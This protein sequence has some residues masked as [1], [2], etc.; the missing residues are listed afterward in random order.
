MFS[1]H[2]HMRGGRVFIAK[3]GGVP[4]FNGELASAI[5]ERSGVPHFNGTRTCQVTLT[6]GPQNT[7]RT[8]PGGGGGLR[9]TTL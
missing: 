3:C 5:A 7:T 9:A 2:D 1:E 8:Q 6:V 4:H